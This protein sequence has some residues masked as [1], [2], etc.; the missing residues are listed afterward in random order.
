MSKQ[1][2]PQCHWISNTHWDREW[3][4]SMQRTR[5]MLVY[6]IDMLLDILEKEPEFNSFHMDSQTIPMQDYLE[7]RPE[8]REQVIKF[9]KE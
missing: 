1:Q 8:R 2:K 3:R 4:Y 5:H 7:I 6:M 9:I